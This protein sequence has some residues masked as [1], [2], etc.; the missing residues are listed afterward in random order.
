MGAGFGGRLRS[1]GD[2]ILVPSLEFQG[3]GQ[4]FRSFPAS[5]TSFLI[6]KQR[7]SK[8]LN[9]GETGPS[10]SAVLKGV[11]RTV[12]VSKLL[13]PRPGNITKPKKSIKQGAPSS[14]GRLS[15]NG[16]SF[17]EELEISRWIRAKSVTDRSS[18][19]DTTVI[20]AVC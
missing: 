7:R 14:L 8:L 6:L 1:L 3:Y 20:E 5:P 12:V 4:C 18:L 13:N 19:E 15:R 17:G 10:V 16:T 2:G 9:T 11:I